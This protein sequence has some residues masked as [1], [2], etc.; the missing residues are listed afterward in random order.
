MT[1]VV[2]TISTL[3]FMVL[4]LFGLWLAGGAPTISFW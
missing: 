1:D 3:L 2:R 4:G